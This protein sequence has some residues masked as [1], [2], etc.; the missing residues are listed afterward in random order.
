MIRH[1]FERFF[2]VLR[3]LIARCATHR[4]DYLLRQIRYSLRVIVSLEETAASLI[5]HCKIDS[6]YEGDTEIPTIK[7]SS[8]TRHTSRPVTVT[9]LPHANECFLRTAF[10]AKSLHRL[11]TSDRSEA[12]VRAR[13]T[14]ITP[15]RFDPDQPFVPSWL[16]VRT[17]PKVSRGVS[18]IGQAPR[19]SSRLAF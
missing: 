18:A 4:V 8:V 10:H 13:P 6:G 5:K 3:T 7:L 2:L 1:I 17:A 14:R 16:K 19:R 15:F 12:T 9:L 11:A